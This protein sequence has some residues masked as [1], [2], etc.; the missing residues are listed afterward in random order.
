MGDE[1]L[2]DPNSQA[3]LD[4]S[5]TIEDSL[6]SMLRSERDLDEQA[7]FSVEVQ[8]FRQGS[9]VCDFKVNYILKEAYVAI[10]FAI[11]PSNITDAM[12]KNFKFKKGIL[13]QRFLIAAG[14]FNSSAPV[15]HCAAKGCSHKCDY[16]YDIEDYLCTCPRSL[17]L[18]NAGKICIT[19]EEAA[20]EKTVDDSIATATQ[21]TPSGEIEADE[22]ATTQVPEVKLTLLPTNCLWLRKEGK[23]KVCSHPRK[24]W[25][26]V[27]W[28]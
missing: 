17:V 18:D 1:K 28:K 25:W 20:T 14:S 12:S 15:D 9:V 27:S 13:F 21:E 23:T 8:K 26:R 10:P 6:E 24:E 7:E 16:D 2:S 22:G 3:Y 4:L 19:P 11:K 5:N